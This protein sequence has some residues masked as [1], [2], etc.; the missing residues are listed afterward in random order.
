VINL[1]HNQLES[2]K[3]GHYIQIF[4]D[5]CAICE[6]HIKNVEIGKCAT[7]TMD[8]LLLD[9]QS[10]EIKEK[11]KNYRI[12][13]HPTTIIDN[14]IKVEGLPSFLWM[15]GDSFYEDLKKKHPFHKNR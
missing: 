10:N 6:T 2:R 9:D 5:S 15:C 12:S 4:S 11:I 13:V 14:E 7:C 1:A 8:I 3:K